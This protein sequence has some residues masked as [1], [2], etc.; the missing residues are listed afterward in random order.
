[1]GAKM[2]GVISFD[3]SSVPKGGIMLKLPCSDNG[4]IWT[5]P[6]LLLLS[7]RWTVESETDLSNC[8]QRGSIITQWAHALADWSAFSYHW[9]HLFLCLSCFHTVMSHPYLFFTHPSPCFCLFLFLPSAGIECFSL[10]NHSITGAV[11]RWVSLLM[12]FNMAYV[13]AAHVIV[14]HCCVCI[15]WSSDFQGYNSPVSAARFVRAESLISVSL[16]GC[17][18]IRRKWLTWGTSKTSFL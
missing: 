6:S 11:C 1:M 12:T 18:Y 3:S 16:S 4:K 8:L 10:L 17:F 15:R 2:R 7:R 9:L 14:L 5:W 13:L